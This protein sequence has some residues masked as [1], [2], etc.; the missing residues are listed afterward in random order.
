MNLAASNVSTPDDTLA[1]LT[2]AASNAAVA[3]EAVTVACGP[4]AALS[5]RQRPPVAAAVGEALANADRHA[6][7]ADASGKVWVTL[8]AHDGRLTLS[9]RDNGVGLPELSDR[10]CPGLQRIRDA[11]AAL[12]GYCRIDN[13]NYGGAEVTLV[14]PADGDA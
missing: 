13:R 10:T 14:F 8:A 11:A 12:R 9:V 2:A 1:F 4:G 3:R 5:A 6:Y 7:P